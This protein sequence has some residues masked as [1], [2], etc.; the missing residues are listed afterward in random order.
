MFVK[1]VGTAQ[2]TAHIKIQLQH[3]IV[4]F[5]G[6]AMLIQPNLQRVAQLGQGAHKG[7]GQFLAEHRAVT[8]RF[9]TGVAPFDKLRVYL[10]QRVFQAAFA[11]A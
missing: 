2:K 11:L 5:A 6:V 10:V 7:V 8:A 1:C 9:L 4:R 3:R